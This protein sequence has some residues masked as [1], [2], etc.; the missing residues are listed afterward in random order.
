MAGGALLE[1]Y[2]YIAR[3]HAGGL[4]YIYIATGHTGGYIERAAC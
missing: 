4:L 1:G 2:I 3:G